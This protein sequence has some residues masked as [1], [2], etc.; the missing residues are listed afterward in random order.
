MAQQQNGPNIYEDLN[1]YEDTWDIGGSRFALWAESAFDPQAYTGTTSPVPLA[2]LSV[3]PTYGNMDEMSQQYSPGGMA[4]SNAAAKPFSFVHSPTP[5]IIVGL[6]VGF[7][8]LHKLYY[9]K[10]DRRK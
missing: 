7:Y 8:A 4:S 5:Y 6:L 10:K 9:S 1:G 2:L 3:P